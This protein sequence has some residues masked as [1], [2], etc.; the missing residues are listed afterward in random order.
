MSDKKYIDRLFQEKLKD[1]EATPNDAIWDQ[2]NQRLHEK[3]RDRK[4]IPIWWKLAGVAAVLA[5]LFTASQLIFN[6]DSKV[7]N[8]NNTIVDTKMN[9]NSSEENNS[10]EKNNND[11]FSSENSTVV[12]HQSNDEKH[13]TEHPNVVNNDSNF[14]NKNNSSIV[15]NNS[16]INNKN[17][18]ANKS[19]NTKKDNNAIVSNP[20]DDKKNKASFASNT[21]NLPEPNLKDSKNESN[22]P[23]SEI[24][25]LIKATKTD[26][27]TTVAKNTSEKEDEILD[28]VKTEEQE[29]AIENAIAEVEDL[30]EKEKEEEKQNRWNISPNVAPVYFNSL[31]KGSTIN[32]EFVNNSKEG[33]I[34]MSYGL[35]GSYAINKKLKIRAGINKLDLG[36]TTN[37]V[38]AYN[39][40]NARTTSE[41][42]GNI[43]YNENSSITFLSA[44]NVSFASAPEIFNANVKG[45]IDQRFGFIE[46]PLE[47]EYSLV[48][49]K[50]GLNVIGGFSTLFLTN[51]EIYSVL[52]GNRTL[53][54]EA[55]NLNDMS[56]S[57]N[58]GLGVNYNVSEKIKVNLE[59]MFKY[60]INTFSNTTG[61]FKPFFIGLY[62]GLS[63]KF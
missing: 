5:L 57:A 8:E 23:K 27:N 62:T 34:N 38:I 16:N 43:T 42:Q 11:S 39:K 44:Q 24:D 59:P 14:I 63:Y 54:G 29:N 2:I 49:K 17:S 50:I 22:K 40:I 32:S 20:K 48:N 7:K 61:D 35:G 53:I 18:K 26:S 30:D 15:E 60:Q 6:G 36:Y 45:S 21:S 9:T 12:N 1:F 28:E 58:F 33:D 25:N 55:S 37:D 4:I 47:L 3:K 19:F 10:K 52:E 31:G 13:N 41:T 46:V 56:Y 51:N